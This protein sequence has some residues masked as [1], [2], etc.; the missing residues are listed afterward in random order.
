[1]NDK[2]LNVPAT[3]DIAAS[4]NHKT[5]I[6]P[7]IVCFLLES[8]KN[9]TL[10]WKLEMTFSMVNQGGFWFEAQIKML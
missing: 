9:Y 6:S 1:M 7:S 4:E 3:V 2:S 5:E 10:N 8:N